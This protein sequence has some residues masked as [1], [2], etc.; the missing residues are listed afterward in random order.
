MLPETGAPRRGAPSFLLSTS[1]GLVVIFLF[2]AVLPCVKVLT[3]DV[4]GRILW[5]QETRTGE[6]LVYGHVHSVEKTLVREFFHIEDD[7]F[8][9][10]RAEMSS[11]GAGLPATHNEGF[12]LVDGKFVLALNISLRELNFLLSPETLPTLT[13]KGEN[14]ALYSYPA[15]ASLNVRIVRRPLL[16]FQLRRLMP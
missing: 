6:E 2:T 4:D 1:L 14:I 10:V 11:I 7:G 13:V 9:L 12:V 16:W 15:T 3:I 8:R 5:A